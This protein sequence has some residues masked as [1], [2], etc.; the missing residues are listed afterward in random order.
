MTLPHADRVE[1]P[2][3]KVASICFLRPIEQGEERP[4]SF[5]R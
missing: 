5:L 2:Q 4:G 3:V 1:V